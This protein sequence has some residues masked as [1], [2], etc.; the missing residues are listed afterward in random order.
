MMITLLLPWPYTLHT[1]H[2]KHIYIHTY[3][4]RRQWR[5]L[6]HRRRRQNR[7]HS[8]WCVR[9]E[10]NRRHHMSIEWWQRQRS[11]TAHAQTTG[12]RGAD[13]HET[14]TAHRQL[15]GRG[16][17]AAAVRWIFS[18]LC[19]MS[20]YIQTH[21]ADMHKLLWRKWALTWRANHRCHNGTIHHDYRTFADLYSDMFKHLKKRT[22]S[23]CS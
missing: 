18:L 21:H 20:L 10:V 9:S 2:L 8:L 12:G 4:I 7:C 17:A 19:M 3:D 23:W 15:Y 5:Q 22:S 6:W 1:Q 14:G 13:A 11:A 16:T